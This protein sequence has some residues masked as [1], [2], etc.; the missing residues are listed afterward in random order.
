MS[1][2]VVVGAQWGDEGKGKIVDM[3]TEKADI[4]ARYQGG[5]NAGHTV[6]INAEKYILN[7]I[8]TGILHYGKTCVIGNGV[9]IDPAGLLAEVDGLKARGV[10]I[11]DRLYISKS[12]HVIMPYHVEI[13][14]TLEMNLGKKMLGTTRRGTGPCYTD[15]VARR[16]IRVM[17]LLTPHVFREKLSENLVRSNFLLEKVYNVFPLN[18]NEIYDS[19]IAY[20]ER[21]KRYIADT[22]SLLSDAV[23][24]GK[25]VL[26]EAA[27]GTLLD[28]DLGTYPYVTSSNT[29]AGGVCC[30]AGIGPT[31][32]DHVLGVSKA[33]TTRVGGGPF[34]TEI[35]DSGICD[36]IRARGMEQGDVTTRPRR[37]GW[38]DI[39]GLRYAAR[40]NGFTGIALTKLDALDELDRIKICTGY[41]YKGDIFKVFPEEP[42]ILA[43][44]KPVYEEME[45]WRE[46]TADAKVFEQLPLNA[47]KYIRRI[48]ELLGTEIKIISVGQMRDDIFILKE[49][50]E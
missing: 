8:P 6:W 33:Y 10:N 22:G 7:M 43:Q 12:A 30:G 15:K 37:C 20:A 21:L 47:Q 14:K 36:Y 16:G 38:L 50:F 46:R 44:A 9:V 17:D 11:E 34:P 18:E 1:T 25:N 26:F 35:N 4:I 13:D 31:K 45:G 29:V 5:N 24:A 48:E 3:L 39:V 28:I 27:Q 19:Y 42:E 32:I 2:K 41:K 40:V 23:E 49:P